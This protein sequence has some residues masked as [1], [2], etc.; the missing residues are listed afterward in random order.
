M[1][2]TQATYQTDPLTARRFDL[3]LTTEI[4]DM[5]K[6]AKDWQ[7]LANDFGKAGRDATAA[8]CQARAR[9]YCNLA[10]GSYERIV[11]ETYVELIQIAA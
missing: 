9:H 8:M 11:R 4:P 2:Q 7:R 6:Y 3:E 1:T 10:G 5:T